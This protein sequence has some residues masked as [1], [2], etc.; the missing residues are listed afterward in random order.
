MFNVPSLG[1]SQ[2]KLF[3][4][5]NS[6][7]I[8]TQLPFSILVLN[9]PRSLP[10]GY[11]RRRSIVSYSHGTRRWK[12]SSESSPRD[13]SSPADLNPCMKMV[14]RISRISFSK[15]VCLYLGF[16]MECKPC[17]MHLV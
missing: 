4:L 15:Q 11:A 7:T 16:A 5:S 2:V 9:M 10:G 17:P 14:R 6:T 13:L 1:H 8:W 3:K 12:K